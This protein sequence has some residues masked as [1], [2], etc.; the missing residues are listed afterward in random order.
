MSRCKACNKRLSQTELAVDGDT[1]GVP[2][3]LCSQCRSVAASPDE[4]D[5][6]EQNI[7]FTLWDELDYGDLD[8]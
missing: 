7:N 4:A 8:E 5:N 3:E 6:L 2:E 1:L